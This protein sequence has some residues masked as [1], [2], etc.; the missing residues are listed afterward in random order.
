MKDREAE[1][2]V[3]KDNVGGGH[4]DVMMLLDLD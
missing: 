1:S 2:A 4:G 3:I